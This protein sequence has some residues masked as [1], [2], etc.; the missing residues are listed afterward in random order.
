[1]TRKS[2]P[3][4]GEKY[5]YYYC[6]TTK[7]RGCDGVGTLKESELHTYITECVKAQ[8]NNILT[9]DSI[10][11]GSDS[12]RA[13]SALAQQYIEQI[14]ENEASIE[15]IQGY[16]R[17]LYES[18][19]QG[20]LSKDDYTAL[21]SKYSADEIRLQ[22]AVETLQKQCGDVLSGKGDQ[23]RWMEHFKRFDGLMELDRRMVISLIHSIRVNSKY[24][25][26]ITYNY[27]AEFE[28]ALEILR[29]LAHSATERGAA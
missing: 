11:A 26:S 9:I 13:G 28:K 16:K 1:M 7:K 17:K 21:K 3:Y 2:V 20:I 12:K 27:Q 10:F 25:L 18:M 22:N 6:P 8:V 14:G 19:I 4:K 29:D 23:M 24:D 15:K 5:H